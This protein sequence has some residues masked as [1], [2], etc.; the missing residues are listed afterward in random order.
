[1]T[2][3]EVMTVREVADYLEVKDRTIDRLVAN[4]EMPDFKVG[5]S[6]RFRKA[7]I[8][9]GTAANAVRPPVGE[10]GRRVNDDGLKPSPGL[11]R[12]HYG[13]NKRA[14]GAR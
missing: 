14:T 8:D 12:A 6:R 13:G 10:S 1:M 3:D 2:D 9:R 7:E 11:R 4:G 5:G